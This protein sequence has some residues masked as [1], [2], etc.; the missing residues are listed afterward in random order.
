MSTF[1]GISLYLLYLT[2]FS[3][4]NAMKN[5][6]IPEKYNRWIGRWLIIVHLLACGLYNKLLHHHHHGHVDLCIIWLADC[7]FVLVLRLVL[8]ERW[9]AGGACLRPNVCVCVC[10]CPQATDHSF[11]PRN[12]ICWHNTPWDMRKKRNLLFFEILIFG[13]LRALF[14]PFSSMFFLIL[15]KSSVRVTSHTDRLTNLIFGT[16][17]LYDTITWDFQRFL[18]MCIS[19]PFRGPFI[20]ELELKHMSHY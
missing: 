6:K 17:S 3:F 15:C 14:Q 19:A 5:T 1:P 4:S 9:R 11:W 8:K 18:K 2:W 10:V 16:E 12:L 7:A 13:P 20:L